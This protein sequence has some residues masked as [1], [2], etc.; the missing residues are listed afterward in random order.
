MEK[1]LFIP[2]FGKSDFIE[3]DPDD[4]LGEFRRILD[5][6]EIETV[7]I[8][9]Q[10]GLIIDAEGK[11]KNP[12]KR[13]NAKATNLFGEF[14]PDHIAGDAILFEYGIRNGEPDITPPE[15]LFIL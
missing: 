5:C 1:Y 6:D 7:Q 15:G 13:F 14:W 2:A 4:L 12:P 10:Y 8:S 3:V 9:R 11:I